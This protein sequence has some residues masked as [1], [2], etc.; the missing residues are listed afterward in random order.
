M[1]KNLSVHRKL[2][3]KRRNDNMPLA[4][5]FINHVSRHLE[6]DRYG[7][8]SHLCDFKEIAKAIMP[9]DVLLI[10][11]TSRISQAIR[12]L[13][14]SPW[15]HSVLYIGRPFDIKNAELKRII[16]KHFK[17]SP[18][19]QLIVESILGQGTVINPLTT[20]NGDHIRIC[21]PSTLLEKD[22]EKIIRYALTSLGKDYNIRQFIDLGR[23]LLGSRL[24]PR[25]WRSSLFKNTKGQATEDICSTMIANAFAS[26]KFPILPRVHIDKHH[27]MRLI[28][29]NPKL[30]T[31]C[32][33]DYSPYFDIIKYPLIKIT[34]DGNYAKLPWLEDV[35]YNDEDIVIHSHDGS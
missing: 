3:L 24:I 29:R 28:R 30:F 22:H 12:R 33:F 20:L 25:K 10:E 6:K 31:P 13:T 16:K 11:G 8:N 19:T 5:W 7:R 14:L 21:R 9:C 1:Q 27:K 4:N 17:G 35:F 23:F 34:A 32:D 2:T 26:V 15:T 18:N